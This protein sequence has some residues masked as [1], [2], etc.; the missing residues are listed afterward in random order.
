MF[1]KN[2]KDSELNVSDVSDNED[3]D[4]DS[5][6]KSIHSY[7]E[8]TNNNDVTSIGGNDTKSVTSFDSYRSNSI[9]SPNN[10]HSH[11]QN[12][13]DVLEG[14]EERMR[15]SVHGGGTGSSNNGGNSTYQMRRPSSLELQSLP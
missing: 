9:I 4:N 11:R 3:E 13:I 1:N 15:F 5:T 6:F 8:I 2:K 7:D 12:V 10:S 14:I